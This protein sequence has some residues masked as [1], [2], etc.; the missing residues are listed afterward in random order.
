MTT[1]ATTTDP[2]DLLLAVFEAGRD[3][4]RHLDAACK[5]EHDAAYVPEELT[6][7]AATDA[8][9]AA[10]DSFR[11]AASLL[12]QIASGGWPV[13]DLPAGQGADFVITEDQAIAEGA[14]IDMHGWGIASFRGEPIA[15]VSRGL[16]SA[17]K[18]AFR[19]AATGGLT[20]TDQQWAEA[21]AEIIDDHTYPEYA[22]WYSQQ[23]NLAGLIKLVPPWATLGDLLQVLIADAHDTAKPGE[24][25][26]DLYATRPVKALQD[27]P[28]WLQRPRAGE[29]TAF[30]PVDY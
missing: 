19:L 20:V 6:T 29:W 17:L 27:K 15:T 9:R 13:S 21:G 26:D 16:F 1:T 30:F 23:D 28:I 24:P 4:S 2:A 25:Q 12:D 11:R 22:A 7:A 10:A 5:A 18:A 14:V 8:Y 3:A